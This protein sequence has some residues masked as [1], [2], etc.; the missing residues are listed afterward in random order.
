MD[1]LF[2]NVYDRKRLAPGQVIATSGAELNWRDLC[3]DATRSD[4]LVRRSRATARWTPIGRALAR[5]L[6]HPQAY[7]CVID[8]DREEI[9]RRIDPEPI[10]IAV[11]A[12]IVGATAGVTSATL[13]SV[14]LRKTHFKAAPSVVRRKILER[15][16][17]V[18]S[19]IRLVS[20][21]MGTIE[22][23]FVAENLQDARS[24]G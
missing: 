15:I 18:E 8:C 1:R 14:N 7:S 20:Q 13:T 11:V 22:D 24:L 17:Q 12:A 4:L 23:I 6:R 21:Y 16:D 19:D 2:G 10:T 3:A 5:D 9:V